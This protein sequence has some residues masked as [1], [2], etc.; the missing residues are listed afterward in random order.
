MNVPRLLL[1]R[2]EKAI[3]SGWTGVLSRDEFARQC[4]EARLEALERL[5]LE[6]GKLGE[7]PPRVRHEE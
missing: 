2:I 4:I 1:E 5:H 7:M 3:Q 6:R